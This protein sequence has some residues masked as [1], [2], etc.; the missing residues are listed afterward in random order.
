MNC[1]VD[2]ATCDD[3]GRTEVATYTG[4][5]WEIVETEHREFYH[6]D[7]NAFQDIYE[8]RSVLQCP[9]ALLNYSDI[10]FSL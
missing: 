2:G 9:Y 10:L 4:T 3:G 5:D 7:N 8:L 1:K 6:T